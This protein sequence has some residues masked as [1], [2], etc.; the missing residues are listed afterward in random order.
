MAADTGDLSLRIGKAE[1]F[2]P[3]WM[4]GNCG[5]CLQLMMYRGL[6][7]LTNRGTNDKNAKRRGFVL[8]SR[9]SHCG[10]GYVAICLAG[11]QLNPISMGPRTRTAG[12]QPQ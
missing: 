12:Q 11:Q 6:P 8:G 7:D 9:W 4:G 5:I 10:V 2:S 3:P 1:E